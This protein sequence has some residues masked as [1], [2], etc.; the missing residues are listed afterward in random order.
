MLIFNAVKNALEKYSEKYLL[1]G[2]LNITLDE[3][4]HLHK[5]LISEYQSIVAEAE[6]NIYSCV[7]KNDLNKSIKHIDNVVL[8]LTS[9]RVL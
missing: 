1:H 7:I 8:K 4:T 5:Y 6:D 9:E 2:N 3:I